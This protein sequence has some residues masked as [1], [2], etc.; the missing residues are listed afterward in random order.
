MLISCSRYFKAIL[1]QDLATYGR[2]DLDEVT[3]NNLSEHQ[4]EIQAAV[5]GQLSEIA[6]EMAESQYDSEGSQEV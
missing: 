2:V 6:I 4:A 5:N 3:N 1:D